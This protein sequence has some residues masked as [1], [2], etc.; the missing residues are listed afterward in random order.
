MSVTPSYYL[1]FLNNFCFVVITIN[2]LHEIFN[3]KQQRN[4][5]KEVE[6]FNNKKERGINVT[7]N[8]YQ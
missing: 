5:T 8:C 2:L 3:K 4:V 1:A 7:I 6:F